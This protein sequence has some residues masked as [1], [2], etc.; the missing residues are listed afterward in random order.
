MGPLGRPTQN[1]EPNAPTVAVLY[2]RAHHMSGNTAF[3]QALWDAPP[4]TRRP[5]AHAP[6]PASAATTFPHRQPPLTPTT[7]TNINNQHTGKRGTAEGKSPRS[8]TQ[9]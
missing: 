5:P 2:Y 8:K 3:V 9:A 1:S 6:P 4:P 7:P